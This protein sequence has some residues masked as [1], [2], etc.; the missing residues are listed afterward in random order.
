LRFWI[1]LLIV[2]AACS[3][4]DPNVADRPKDDTAAD[5]SSV[6]LLFGG[7]VMF[8]R[9]VKLAAEKMTLDSLLVHLKPLSERALFFSVNL[10]TPCSQNGTPMVKQFVFNAPPEALAALRKAGVTAVNLANNHSVDYGADGLRD[11]W[12]HL[13]RNE[14]MYSGSANGPA[15][16]CRPLELKKSGVAIAVFSSV[17][18]PLER[19]Y[20]LDGKP[21]VCTASTHNLA[22]SIRAYRS[23]HADA[24]IVVQLHWG[25][26]YA[27][28]P[29]V[30]QVRSAREL[31][32]AGSDII[33]GH[34]PHVLQTISRIEGIPVL[35][36]LG[37]LVFD[38][39]REY[40]DQSAILAIDVRSRKDFAMAL[41]PLSIVNCTPQPA[42]GQEREAIRERLMGI[43]HGI[44]LS[45]RPDGGWNLDFS[46]P[47]SDAAP[48]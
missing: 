43:S 33:V 21:C 1:S 20:N 4:A 6:T 41:H 27:S 11:T 45:D 31:A 12:T 3:H 39:L 28:G 13:E 42:R 16:A 23:R 44:M 2:T 26:E 47:P 17:T 32:L 38:P 36:S 5:T 14:L 24:F 22:D 19:W 7:D 15:L 40:T 10:E 29:T 34:H 18:L 8:D 35:F 9:G 25:T 46:P 37:N 30:D 48:Q